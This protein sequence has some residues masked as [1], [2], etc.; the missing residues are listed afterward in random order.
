MADLTVAPGDP[1]S[2]EAR[3]LLGASHRLMR[4]M[5]DPESNHF[6]DIDALC[7]PHIRFFVAAVDGRPVGCGALALKDG[8]GEVK[9]MFVA[10]AARGSGAGAALLERI[11]AEA[12]AASLPLLRLETGDA[13]H[14]AHRLYARAGFAPRGPFGDYPE[15]PQSVFMEK[16]LT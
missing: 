2:P 10:P 8:Y 12:R 16:R 13:L 7:D 9:S 3:A 14:A 15:H 5:F 6:L 11:E 1:R 4:E